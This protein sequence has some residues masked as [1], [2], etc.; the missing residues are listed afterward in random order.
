SP[1]LQQIITSRTDLHLTGE[2]GFPVGPLARPMRGDDEEAARAAPAV[3]LFVARAQAA[4]R[5]FELSAENVADVVAL[6]A[7]L[8]ALPLAIELAAARVKI[9]SPGEL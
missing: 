4:K 9:L 5:D 7:A 8:D 3:A 1:E 6:C 2:Y